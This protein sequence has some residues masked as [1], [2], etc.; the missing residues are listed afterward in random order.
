MGKSQCNSA[1]FAPRRAKYN[2][3]TV[4]RWVGIGLFKVRVR[5][6]N[7]KV[8]VRVFNLKEEQVKGR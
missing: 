5:V 6:F 4:S 8:R 7:L 3:H 1:A 2:T